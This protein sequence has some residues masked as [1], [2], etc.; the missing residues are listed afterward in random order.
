[1]YLRIM[2]SICRPRT[3]LPRDVEY[4]NALSNETD[5]VERCMIATLYPYFRHQILDIKIPD[6]GVPCVLGHK[7]EKYYICDRPDEHQK[8]N[9]GEI[10]IKY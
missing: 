6:D 9:D 7:Y 3:R 2:L 4:L 8:H 1:M 5:T 10:T